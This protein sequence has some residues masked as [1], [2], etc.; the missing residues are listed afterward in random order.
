MFTQSALTLPSGATRYYYMEACDRTGICHI[1]PRSIGVHLVS[2]TPGGGWVALASGANASTGFISSHEPLRGSWGGFESGSSASVVGVDV[3]VG[4][5]SHG[6]QIL[7]Y[8]SVWPESGGWEVPG[9]AELECSTA[10]RLTVRATNCAGQ[11][12][13]R[14]ST[15]VMVCCEPPLVGKVEILALQGTPDADGAAALLQQITHVSEQTRAV[16]RWS[17]FEE[18]CSG[19]ARYRWQL[20][21]DESDAVLFR[22]ADLTAGAHHGVMSDTLVVAEH[23]ALLSHLQP[24][25]IVVIAISHAGLEAQASAPFIADLEPPTID[26]V[27]DGDTLDLACANSADPYVCSWEGLSDAMAGLARVEWGIGSEPL[28]AD[29]Y[30]FT[31]TKSFTTGSAATRGAPLSNLT[32]GTMVYCTVRATDRAGL[33]ALRSSNGARLID[34]S[35]ADPFVCMAT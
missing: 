5:T 9:G 17:G 14:V 21:D 33:H 29:L 4:T 13:V 6:C 8:M 26:A 23:A 30:N 16:L 27:W 7:D 35:C 10:Y 24:Y 18:P 34:Q 19:V 20:I 28:M 15:S 3:C 32:A 31:A 22:S 1:S 12:T 2:D 11:A 25:R